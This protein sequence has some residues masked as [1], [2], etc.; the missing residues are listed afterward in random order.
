MLFLRRKLVLLRQACRGAVVDVPAAAYV[1]G[2]MLGEID[3]LIIA[4]QE[5]L[6]ALEPGAGIPQASILE[7]GPAEGDQIN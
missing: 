4:V 2:T 6:Q 1:T 7:A 5:G 3:D